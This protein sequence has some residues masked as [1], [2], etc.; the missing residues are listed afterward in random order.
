MLDDIGNPELERV[1]VMVVTL[2]SLLEV[3]GGGLIDVVIFTLLV[4]DIDVDVTKEE[5]PEEAAELV[6]GYTVLGL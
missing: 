1:P 5:L 3:A 2:V 4:E 6:V